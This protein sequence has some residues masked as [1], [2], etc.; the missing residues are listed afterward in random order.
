MRLLKIAI[1]VIVLFCALNVGFN[2]AAIAAS[3]NNQASRQVTLD[4]AA[5]SVFSAAQQ[6]FSD[7]S[8]GEWVAADADKQVVVGLSRTN[9]FKF[10]DDIVVTV[11]P[12]A[13]DPAKTLLSIQSVGRQGEYDFGGNQRNIDEYV[14]TLKSLL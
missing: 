11:A 7:W 3:P 13:D 4:V 5:D 6:A 14:E 12:N 8:R 9:M 10:V 2:P 1:G